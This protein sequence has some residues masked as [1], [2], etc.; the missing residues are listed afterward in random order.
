M[1]F[2]PSGVWCEAWLWNE[3][4]AEPDNGMYGVQ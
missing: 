3:Q 1:T 4:S 2:A